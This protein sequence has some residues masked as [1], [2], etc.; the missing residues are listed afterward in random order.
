MT[1]KIRSIDG[2]R[3][4][5]A[6]L[7]GTLALEQ[8]R[9]HL[10]R[11]NVFPVPDG[12][13]GDNMVTT[14]RAITEHSSASRSI[15]RTAS[16]MAEAALEGARGNSG[17]ILA[18]FL[19]GLSLSLQVQQSQGTKTF[20]RGLVQ[21]VPYAEKALYRPIEGTVLTVLREWA[22]QMEALAQEMTDFAQL[23]PASLAAA[24]TSL[25]ATPQKLDVLAREKVVDAGAQ[26]LVD[27]LQGIADFIEKG[28]LK[29]LPSTMGAVP[30]ENLEHT[31]HA[32]DMTFRYCTETLIEGEALS[33]ESLM[34]ELAGFGDS[35]V[36]GGH[37]NRF[38]LHLHT[39]QPAALFENLSAWGT[40]NGQKVDD[41]KRQVHAQ[42][43]KTPSIALLTDSCCDLPSSLMD[44]YGIHMV[45]LKL[46][47]EGSTYLDKVTLHPERIYR[48][49]AKSRNRMTTSQPSLAEFTGMY[50]F[51]KEHYDSVIAIHLS[52][53]LSGTW[54]T[55][56]QAAE[57]VDPDGIHVIDSK[58]LSSGLGLIVL[59][60]VQ[61]ISQGKG[62]RDVV[63]LIKE[64]LPKNRT[65]VSLDTLKY[66]VQGGRIRP[67]AGFMAGLLNLKPIIT[68]D[69]EG[70]G[71]HFGNACGQKANT[72]KILDAFQNLQA[73]R[74]IRNY[75]VVH[76]GAPE[77]A[78]HFA[79]ELQ[80]RSGM[81]PA[82][83]M[84]I[85]PVIGINSG[86]G[87]V[88]VS[89]ILEK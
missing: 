48:M 10:N 57:T 20:A 35:V 38:R 53:T 36:V 84:E 40:L 58:T 75:A 83:V 32:Q 29:N 12:D 86:P 8:H 47:F 51:L 28:N 88:G 25:E 39:D 71:A 64:T 18:Q 80:S 59:Q 63:E 6:F 17:L 81:K 46:T 66:M 45:P 31:H 78:R 56:R 2:F 54:N 52:S 85:S 4:R 27:F 41:I 7:A 19:Y 16:S 62:T 72:R 24:R 74:G 14:C 89:M 79:R 21:A 1:D 37:G 61:A 49:L 30:R 26:G 76:A 23:V 65:L 33:R 13:T 43:G 87:S 69:E 44:E 42:S 60:A 34:D 68:V 11:I 50:S 55:S 82:Y 70:R 77:K 5:N 9:E 73:T 67:V 3:L 22:R 15:G